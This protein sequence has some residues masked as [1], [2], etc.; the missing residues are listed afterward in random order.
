MEISEKIENL[1]QLILKLE[2]VEECEALFARLDAECARTF[3][4]E[5]GKIPIG[6]ARGFARFDPER[7]RSFG[8]VFHR[9]D[10]AMYANKRKLKADSV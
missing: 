1:Y 8:D 9:A 5:A 6:I 3:I 2:S 4:D 7:D 10:N